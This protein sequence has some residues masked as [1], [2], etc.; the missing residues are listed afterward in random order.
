MNQIEIVARSQQQALEKAAEKLGAPL[1]D[2]DVIEEYEPDAKDLALLV[3]EEG[4]TPQEGDAG[5][6]VIRVS[7]GSA[8]EGVQEWMDG[9]L[10]RFKPGTSCEV[11]AEQDGLTVMID[12]EDASI[13]IGRQGQTLHA[14][15]H[16]I[17]R[18][19]G[20]AVPNCPTIMV[21]VGQYREKRLDQLERVAKNAAEKALRTK[22]NVELRPMPS[23]DRK[24]VHNC[25]KSFQGVTTSSHGRDPDRYI[26]IEVPGGEGRKPGRATDSQSPGNRRRGGRGG[27]GRNRGGGEG[28]RQGERQQGRQRQQQQSQPKPPVFQ[29]DPENDAPPEERHWEGSQP[30]GPLRKKTLEEIM[31][32]H[33]G[34]IGSL[35]NEKRLVQGSSAD[36]GE[37]PNSA[38]DPTHRLADELE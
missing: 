2:L 8:I 27:R 20:Q 1:E 14:L 22:R 35:E 36:A 10:E 12:A 37:A 21:D 3:E 32:T 38:F 5:L 26:V 13:F 34:G 7:M 17:S 6:Y 4:G 33:L 28:N 25:L 18:A 24:Y 31:S 16:V 30:K 15:Q 29:P 9:F 23:E 11:I 19:L